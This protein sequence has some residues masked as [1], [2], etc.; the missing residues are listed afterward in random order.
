MDRKISVKPI[1]KKKNRKNKNF[2]HNKKSK[3]AKYGES[4]LQLAIKARDENLIQQLIDSK[5]D[6]NHK[7][8]NKLTALH[9]AVRKI[10]EKVFWS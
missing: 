9:D 10:F 2:T 5:H 1:F 7:D 3:K 8:N 4:S 6:I